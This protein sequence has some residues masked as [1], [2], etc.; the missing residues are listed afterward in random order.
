MTKEGLGL[1][2]EPCPEATQKKELNNAV[3]FL[4]EMAEK[5]K[6]DRLAFIKGFGGVKV[7]PSKLLTDYDLIVMVGEG[8]WAE[9]QEEVLND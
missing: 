6:L 9:L 3:E 5:S 1:D 7:V 4:V 2:E 8:Y